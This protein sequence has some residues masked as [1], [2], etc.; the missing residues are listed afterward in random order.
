MDPRADQPDAFRIA[1]KTAMEHDLKSLVAVNLSSNIVNRYTHALDYKISMIKHRINFGSSVCELTPYQHECYT[2]L[3]NS[4]KVE[5][6]ARLMLALAHLKL[7]PV[8]QKTC[9]SINKLTNKANRCFQKG[10][11]VN[12]VRNLNHAISIYVA[13][14]PISKMENQDK[15]KL[16]KL[17]AKRAQSNLKLGKDKKSVATVQKVSFKLI[18]KNELKF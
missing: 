6:S 15:A 11:F 18:I 13:N 10:H 12:A 1:L 2:E 9:N 7:M 16:A 3:L 5:D 4:T 8:D 14:K 17:Y